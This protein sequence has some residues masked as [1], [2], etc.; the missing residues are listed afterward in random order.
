MIDAVPTITLYQPWATWVAL[1]WKTIETR[2]HQRLKSLAGKWI[3][4]HA[5]KHWDANAIAP[6]NEGAI[7]KIHGW[8]RETRM[9]RNVACAVIA[10]AHVKEHRWL[11]ARDSAAALC[12]C[13]FYSVYGLVFDQIHKLPEPV[14]MPGGRLIWY[15]R[16]PAVVKAVNERVAQ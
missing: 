3:G 7:M 11:D 12:D 16:H 8:E 9:A 4:I 5:G 6:T 2:A 1:G 13:G 15:C 10:I 14:P